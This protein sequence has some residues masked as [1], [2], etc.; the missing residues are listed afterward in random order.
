LEVY[1]PPEPLWNPR[2]RE[3]ATT[4]AASFFWKNYP[5]TRKKNEKLSKFETALQPNGYLITSNGKSK[6]YLFTIKILKSC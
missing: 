4:L 6:K 1:R 5:K 3:A 2:L